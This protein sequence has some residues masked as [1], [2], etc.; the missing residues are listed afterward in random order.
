M[1]SRFYYT[2][3]NKKLQPVAKYRDS[4]TKKRPFL[5][6][7]GASHRSVRF[8]VV[9]PS[10][11]HGLVL[12][13]TL[14]RS[15]GGRDYKQK[16]MDRPFKPKYGTVSQVLLELVVVYNQTEKTRKQVTSTKSPGKRKAVNVV[17]PI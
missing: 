11:E 2:F 17:D 3:L 13:A 4:L 15:G 1:A 9:P 5:L 8:K 14:I 10:F 6:Q 12:L 16:I 7:I